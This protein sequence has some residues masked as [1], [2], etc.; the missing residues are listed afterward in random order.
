MKQLNRIE[1]DVLLVSKRFI[2]QETVL[3]LNKMLCP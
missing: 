2:E 1:A 3:A